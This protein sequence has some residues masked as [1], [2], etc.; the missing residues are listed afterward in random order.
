MESIVQV[1]MTRNA[2]DYLKRL[3]EL[4]AV[5]GVPGQ[6][7]VSAEVRP[8]IEAL[9]H[10]LAGGKVTVTIQQEG[11][12]VLVNGLGT[13]LQQTLCD[14]SAMTIARDPKTYVLPLAG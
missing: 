11:T 10:V 9:H 8:I 3:Q 4:G 6:A 12:P 1:A 13:L 2:M 5:E 7:A 14:A